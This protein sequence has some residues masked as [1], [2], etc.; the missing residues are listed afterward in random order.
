[1]LV[2]SK[3]D[4][5]PRYDEAGARH[6]RARLDYE[7]GS[8]ASQ[9]GDAYSDRF[10]ISFLILFFVFKMKYICIFAASHLLLW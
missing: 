5:P 2:Q 3:D 1:M 9:Y 4:I 8:G 10:V 6:A 7:L